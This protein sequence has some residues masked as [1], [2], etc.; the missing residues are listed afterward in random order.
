MIAVCG[1]S[2]EV[3]RGLVALLEDSFNIVKRS[4]LD[5]ILVQFEFAKCGFTLQVILL[6]DV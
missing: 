6:I 3:A 1:E 2:A 4:A 5:L